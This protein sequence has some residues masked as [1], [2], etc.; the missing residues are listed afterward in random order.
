MASSVTDRGRTVKVSTTISEYDLAFL[1][2]Y[3]NRHRLQSR[4]AGFHDAI[5]ALREKELEAQYEE[6][7]Q[8]WYESG[9]AEVW[10]CVSGDGIDSE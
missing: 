2:R 5:S 1:E 9:E 8:E 3:A 10:E 7:Y 4:A 6:A